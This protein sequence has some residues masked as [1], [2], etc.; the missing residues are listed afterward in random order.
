MKTNIYKEKIVTVLKKNHLLSIADIQKKIPNVD[1][2]TVYR[3]IEQLTAD[4]TIKK[5]VLD[6]DKIF[7]EINDEHHTHDHFLC[8]GCGTVDELEKTIR[9][10]DLLQKYTIADVVIKGLCRNCTY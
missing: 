3:N 4:Q 10:T 1:Y 2:S 8:T 7:Y 6:K 9:D 5:V